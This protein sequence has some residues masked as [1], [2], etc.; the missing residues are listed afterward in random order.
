MLPLAEAIPSRSLTYPV[1]PSWVMRQVGHADSKMTMD[2]YAQLQQRAE[3]QHGEA[4]DALVRRARVRLYGT[5]ARPDAPGPS[6]PAPIAHDVWFR[7]ASSTPTE[8][9]TRLR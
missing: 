9:P 2:V 5:T 7:P 8:R 4:F 6:D 3:R 1:A